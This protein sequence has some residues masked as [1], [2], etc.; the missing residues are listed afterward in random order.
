[1][2]AVVHNEQM[3]AELSVLG[4]DT[5]EK[6][7]RAQGE[8]VKNQRGRRDILR[9]QEGGK[10]FFLKRILRAYRK[11]GLKSLLR[12]G[13]VWSMA[14]QEW[15]NLKL[16]EKAGL[17]VPALV[18]YGEECG[19]LW[20][21]FSYIITG[22]AEGIPLDAWFQANADPAVRRK[23]I[24]ALAHFLVQ[25]HDAGLSS[26]DLFA[27]HIFV[28]ESADGFKFTLIDMARIDQGMV[29]LKQSARDL[30]ALHVSLPRKSVGLRERWVF[31]QTY[32]RRPV[33]PLARLIRSRAVHLLKR[34]KF[35]AF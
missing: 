33:A 19:P 35:R 14:R 3:E 11:D 28:H 22:N 20:E 27:R 5:L 12:R 4:L 25:F 32:R 21:R 10:T 2:S 7:R 18:A 31:L 9:F 34:K 26:P 23:L 24:V 16:I 1:M 6:V 29:G 17:G 8:V 30:A 15:E 13:R